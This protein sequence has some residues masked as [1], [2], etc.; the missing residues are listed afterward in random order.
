MDDEQWEIIQWCWTQP[1]E[2]RPDALDVAERIVDMVEKRV[3]ETAPPAESN[4][5]AI[6]SPEGEEKEPESVTGD[7]LS[8]IS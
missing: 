3:G 8:D 1:P 5:I 2:D 4:E 7:I 6:H